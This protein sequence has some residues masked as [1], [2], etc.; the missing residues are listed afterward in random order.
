M[1]ISEMI[2]S[3][4]NEVSTL[5]KVMYESLL[6]MDANDKKYRLLN[7]DIYLGYFQES[8]AIFE[9]N[10]QQ[11]LALESPGYQVDS[12]WKQL[13]ASYGAHVRSINTGD[14]GALP[15]SGQWAPEQTI[16]NWLETISEARLANEIEIEKSLLTINNKGKLSVR[17]GMI[18]MGIT[19]IAGLAAALFLSKSILHPLKE[20]K[21]ALKSISSEKDSEEIQINSKDEF[22]ELAAAFND[23]SRQLKEEE[24]LRS[25]FIATLSHEIRTPLSSIKESVNMILEG[26]LGGT[27]EKQTKFLEIAQSEIY[28]IHDLLNHLLQVSRLDSESRKVTPVLIDPNKL[29]LEVSRSLIPT[30]RAKNVAMKLYKMAEPPVLIGVK[31]ELQQVLFNLLDNAI[32]FSPKGGEVTIS[33]LLEKDDNMLIY[34]VTDQG[35][36][37]SDQEHSLIFSKYYRAKR[38]RSHTDGVGLGLSISKRIIQFHGGEIFVKNN[39]DRGCSFFCALPCEIEAKRKA[40]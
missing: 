8:Q 23:M 10:L 15:E 27:N 30:A 16:N 3:K 6:S 14:E 4:N 24:E 26:V 31:K 5:S 29:V 34:K 37:V 36:G 7:K 32:K 17:N 19:I 39:T 12:A 38:A 20:L 22:G 25:E 2:V 33:L 40:A 18:G 1:T 35:P 9:S 13:S 28:R 11:L 21:H